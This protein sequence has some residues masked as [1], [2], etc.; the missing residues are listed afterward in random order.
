MG[1][2]EFPKKDVQAQGYLSGDCPGCG[3]RRLELYVDSDGER[4][5]GIQCEK[6]RRQWL[7]DPEKAN[8]YGEHDDRDPL[9]PGPPDFFGLTPRPQGG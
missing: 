8:F 1:E 3:R 7:L 4:A 9:H 6:C 2:M 5:V